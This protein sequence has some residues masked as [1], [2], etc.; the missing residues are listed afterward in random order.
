MGRKVYW[1]ICTKDG[2]SVNMT[3]HIYSKKKNNNFFNNIPGVKKN[4]LDAQL[5]LSIYLQTPHVSVVSRPIIR[6]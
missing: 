1:A 4:Q 2:M 3:T 6:R 5:I